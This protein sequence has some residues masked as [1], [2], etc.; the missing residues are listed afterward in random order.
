M[1]VFLDVKKKK[2]KEKNVKSNNS[3][4]KMVMVSLKEFW[5]GKKKKK[6]A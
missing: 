1:E 5:K 4:N 3:R 6:K 2:L